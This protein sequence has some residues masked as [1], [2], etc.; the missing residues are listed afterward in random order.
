MNFRIKLPSLVFVVFGS[1]ILKPVPAL[2]QAA[3]DSQIQQRF[4]ARS[5]AS[6]DAK[7]LRGIEV[8]RDSLRGGPSVLVITPDIKA[9]QA[10][11]QWI[12]MLQNELNVSDVGVR[13]LLVLDPDQYESEREMMRQ[14]RRSFPEQAWAHTWI[15]PDM[16]FLQQ[17]GLEDFGDQVTVLVLDSSAQIIAQVIGEPTIERFRHVD[18]T[19]LSAT[20]APAS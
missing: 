12:Q 9:A 14:A 19:L 5:T 8:T 1:L 10:S 16:G 13:Q 20:S 11:K 18:A 7:S 4:P 6:F 17:L 3:G 15:V 2:P